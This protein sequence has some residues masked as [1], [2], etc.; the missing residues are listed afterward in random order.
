MINLT[1]PVIAAKMLTW[2]AIAAWACARLSL[3]NSTE[4]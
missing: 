1:L 4:M 2:L 3:D